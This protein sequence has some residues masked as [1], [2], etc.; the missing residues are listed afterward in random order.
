M[1]TTL[2]S[3][4]TA[5][6]SR[7]V[8]GARGSDPGQ[9]PPARRLRRAGLR[10]LRLWIGVAIMAVAMVAGARVLGGGQDTVMVWR[11]TRDLPAGSV[12]AA[13]PFEVQ[14]GPAAGAYLPASRSLQGRV[15]TPVAAGALIPADA[16]GMPSTAGM[17][18][19]TLAVDPLHSPVGVSAGDAV[20]IWATGIDGADTLI[21]DP[22]LILPSVLVSEVDADHLGVS[23][24]MAV[25]VEVPEERASELVAAAR[26]RVLDLVAVPLGAQA[27]V[28]TTGA[29][30]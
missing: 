2:S 10:D 13:E 19:V 8:P 14:L 6:S 3:Q 12:P 26:S 23:G 25:V 27:Q 1:I 4:S 7:S 29:R 22:Q 24:E 30:S 15:R 16:I 11:A 20:D 21:A 5:R 9:P 28:D 17:R 18:L